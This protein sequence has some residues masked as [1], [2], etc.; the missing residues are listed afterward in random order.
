MWKYVVPPLD[1]I[2]YESSSM[3]SASSQIMTWKLWINHESSAYILGLFLISS[4]NL[5]EHIYINSNSIT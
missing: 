3:L 4:C 2:F 1:A 5:N